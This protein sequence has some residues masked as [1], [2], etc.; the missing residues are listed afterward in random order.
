MTPDEPGL[1]ANFQA[2]THLLSR[3]GRWIKVQKTDR[4]QPKQKKGEGEKGKWND[5]KNDDEDVRPRAR[6]LMMQKKLREIFENSFSE[7]IRQILFFALFKA[8]E[9][10]LKPF[11]GIK[12]L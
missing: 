9:R 1:P 10:K 5:K 2:H 11:F 6:V 4:M 8:F 7:W 3:N 12:K